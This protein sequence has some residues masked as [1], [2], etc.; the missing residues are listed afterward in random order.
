[1]RTIRATVRRPARVQRGLA[2][3]LLRAVTPA[4]GAPPRGQVE[5]AADALYRLEIWGREWAGAK[6]PVTA[7]SSRHVALVQ[8]R[9]GAVLDALFL[10]T[11][12]AVG[13]Q[14]PQ[15]DRVVRES[16]PNLRAGMDQ[17]RPRWIRCTGG[18]IGGR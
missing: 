14:T 11:L 10:A 4:T 1:V 2:L 8:D 6:G 15:R 9:G 3:A 17:R 7:H 5:R 13:G 16:G 18:I 12:D